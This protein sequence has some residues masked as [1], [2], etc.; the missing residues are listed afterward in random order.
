MKIYR[1][2]EAKTNQ[3]KKLL[4]NGNITEDQFNKA[5]EF[6]KT[7]SAFENEIDWNRGLKITWDD[8]KAVIYKER[9]SKSKTRKNIRKGLEGFEEGKDYIVLDGEV[10][11]IDPGTGRILKG[12]RYADGL[13]QAIEAKEGVNIQADTRTHA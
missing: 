9:N 6:F 3:L 10:Q 12:R 4:K 2:K 7:Y 8:L 13:H 5:D 11:I 1:L